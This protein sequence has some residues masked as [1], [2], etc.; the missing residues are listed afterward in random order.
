MSP[1]EPLSGS[2]EGL[3]CLEPLQAPLVLLSVA[4]SPAQLQG[5]WGV[6]NAISEALSAAPSLGVLLTCLASKV[7]AVSIPSPVDNCLLSIYD[8]PGTAALFYTF[9]LYHP[10]SNATML[11]GSYCSFC[12]T[13][14]ETEAQRCEGGHPE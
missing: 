4:G 5:E 1:Q 9:K 12:R 7:A 13:K 6:R 14:E 2:E 10:R 11:Q 8:V 3:S